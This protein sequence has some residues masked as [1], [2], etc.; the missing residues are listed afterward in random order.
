MPIFIKICVIKLPMLIKKENAIKKENSKTCTAWEHN[1]P[2]KNLSYATILIDGRYPETKRVTNLEC[3]EI[4]FVRV[5]PGSPE[6]CPLRPTKLEY[7]SV[8]VSQAPAQSIPK[9]E[10]FKSTKAIPTTSR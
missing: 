3:E 7:K 2:T 5:C 8:R 4:I 9:K 10:T 6:P 1:H